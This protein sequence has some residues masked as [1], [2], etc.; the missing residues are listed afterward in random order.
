MVPSPPHAARPP[1]VAAL[2]SLVRHALGGVLGKAGFCTPVPVWGP[3]GADTSVGPDPPHPPPHPSACGGRGAP[4]G[5]SVEQFMVM[6]MATGDPNGT[7][8]S[9]AA[10]SPP[11]RGGE[12]GVLSWD[13]RPFLVKSIL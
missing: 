9:A 3:T 7:H 11:G 5:L 4:A 2:H 13:A 12:G 1:L 8:S 6:A 10:V